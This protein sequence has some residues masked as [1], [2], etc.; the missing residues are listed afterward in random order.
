MSAQVALGEFYFTGKF[1]KNTSK[2]AE[3]L[4]M[5]S[6]RGHMD[7]SYNLAVMYSEGDG[8]KQNLSKSFDLFDAA[9]NL[10]HTD[11]I[12]NMGLLWWEGKGRPQNKTLA[13]AAWRVAADRGNEAA[14]K[15]LEEAKD[16]PQDLLK[17]AFGGEL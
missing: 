6:E 10:N 12:F 9:A 14:K 2:A 15:R 4:E 16:K 17:L 3:Y 7:A 5:A 13:I 1:T 11:A 8:V